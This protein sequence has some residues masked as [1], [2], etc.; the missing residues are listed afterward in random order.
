MYFRITQETHKHD[1]AK[2]GDIFHTSWG[3]EQTN[4][5]FFKIVEISKTGKTCDVVQIAGEFIG[6]ENTI[7][8]NMSGQKVPNPDKVINQTPC[9]VKIERAHSA[10]PWSGK[11]EQIGEIMLRGSVYYS[12]GENKHLTNLYRVTGPVSVSWYA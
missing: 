7:S 3:Y 6:D 2:V 11:S 4:S 12:T 1:A 9:K 10:N 8:R 5:E